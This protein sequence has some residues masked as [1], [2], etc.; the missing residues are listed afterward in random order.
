M[1]KVR[2]YTGIFMIVGLVL[3]LGQCAI[4]TADAEAVIEE[5]FGVAGAAAWFVFAYVLARAIE[6]IAE[7]TGRNNP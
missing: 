3:G 1:K 2:F 4:I 6:N 7:W 5:I